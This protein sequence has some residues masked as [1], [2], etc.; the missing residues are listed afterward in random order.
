M[1]RG[2]PSLVF[3]LELPEQMGGCKL[4]WKDGYELHVFGA[5]QSG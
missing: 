4:V 2:R 1:G 3:K 5:G